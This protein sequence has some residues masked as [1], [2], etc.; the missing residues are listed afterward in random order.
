M[1][2]M[3]SPRM[4]AMSKLTHEELLARIADL[5]KSKASTGLKVSTKGAVSL[6]GIGRWPVTL[7]KSQWE[8]VI[9]MVQDGTIEQFIADN[10]D[11]LSVKAEKG[12]E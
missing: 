8:R 2:D 6:Y 10:A 5:E 4:Q 11:K 9:A 1:A 12:A 7:Y 3:N